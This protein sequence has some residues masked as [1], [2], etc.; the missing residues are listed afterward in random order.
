MVRRIGDQYGVRTEGNLLVGFKWIGGCMDEHGPDK[1]ILG[2]EE[3]HG[4]LV[5][6]YARDKDGAVAAL[7]LCELAATVKAAGLS[8]SQK[9]D[10]LYQQHGYHAERLVTQMMPGSEGMANMKKLMERLR[11]EPPKSL[12]GTDVARVRDFQNSKIIAADG[13][14]SKLDAPVGNMVIIDLADGYYVAV[15]P[16][17]TEPKVKY[18][19]FAFVDPSEIN[20]LAAVKAST[21]ERLDAIEKNL[22]AF[23]G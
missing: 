18:Y 2:T 7:L 19:M 15:R 10:S 21:E 11:S 1:F 22:K 16:S 12:A 3:S 20:D 4:Y 17:G 9:L 14:T 8:L 13:S 6:Q 5:G 23:A